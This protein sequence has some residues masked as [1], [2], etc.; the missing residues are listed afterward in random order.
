MQTNTIEF[1]A[2]NSETG[3]K[4]G[5][6]VNYSQWNYSAYAKPQIFNKS[7]Q[8]SNQAIQHCENFVSMLEFR[9]QNVFFIRS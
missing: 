6:V 8:K 7:E 5:G 4:A 1:T 9:T 2:I 3:Y